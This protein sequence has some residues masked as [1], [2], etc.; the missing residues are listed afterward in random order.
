LFRARFLELP[1]S[2]VSKEMELNF[3]IKMLEFTDS[4]NQVLKRGKQ[5]KA[6]QEKLI[7]HLMMQGPRPSSSLKKLAKVN[8]PSAFFGLGKAK[9]VKEHLLV[10]Y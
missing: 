1:E 7:E 2:L 5:E 4:M 3:Y 8:I 10:I 6:H 9:K